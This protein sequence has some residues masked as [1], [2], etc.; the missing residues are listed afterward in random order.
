MTSKVKKL[1]EANQDL[2]AAF[3]KQTNDYE[4][5]IAA[6]DFKLEE[7]IRDVKKS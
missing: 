1:E 7:K 6:L 4:G 2:L 3:H 5:L